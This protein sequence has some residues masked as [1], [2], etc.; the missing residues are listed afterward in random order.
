MT[1]INKS[2]KLKREDQNSV[3]E[4]NVGDKC[5]TLSVIGQTKF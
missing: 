3:G 5:A 4:M 1:V 2:F